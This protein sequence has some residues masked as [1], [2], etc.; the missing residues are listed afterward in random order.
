MTFATLAA[1]LEGDSVREGFVRDLAIVLC[2]A[3]V[4]T[5]LFSRL[6]QPVVLGYLLAGLIV[7]PYLTPK[8][9]TDQESIH[10]LSALGVILLMFSLGLEFR[11]QKIVELGSSAAFVAVVEVGLMLWLG[12]SAGRLL[13]WTSRECLF[14]GGIVAVSSTMLVQKSFTELGVEKRIREIVTGILV[15]EDIVAVV[16]IATL[17]AFSTGGELDARVVAEAGLRL[18][19]FLLVTVAVGLATVPRAIRAILALRR[20][21]T[22]LV[23]CI[24]LSFAMALLAERW[25][26]SQALGAFLAGV[27]VAESGEG[28]WIEDLVRPVRDVF[29]AIFFVSVGMLIDPALI[30]EHWVAV[31]VLSVLVLGGKVTG[32]SFATFLTGKDSATALRAGLCMAQIGELSFVIAALGVTTHAA[33]EF[34][35]PVAVGVSSLT[36]FLSPWLVRESL[37]IAAWLEAH[38]PRPIATFNRLYGSWLTAIRAQ[39]KR[40]ARWRVVRRAAI[41]VVL[42]G[43]LLGALIVAGS[44]GGERVAR[45][46]V[47]W[48]G[49]APR[50]AA[51]LVVGAF[52]GAC[53]F[54]WIGIARGARRLAVALSEM[55]MPSS[56]TGR[57]DSAAAPRRAL[58]VG[59]QLAVVVCVGIPLAVVTEPFLPHFS[60]PAVL[61]LLVA[62]ISFM[63][64]RSAAN[65]EGHVRAGAE[66]IVEALARGPKS[67]HARVMEEVNAILPGLGELTMLRIETGSAATSERL[68]DLASGPLAGVSVVAIVRGDVHVTL[69]GGNEVLHEGDL[70]ALTGAPDS[71]ARAVRELTPVRAAV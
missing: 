47:E 14:A 42:D 29:A 38:L 1:L 57:M 70:V 19:G 12:V 17:T 54:P 49:I 18:G 23:A 30:L 9:V 60:S 59:L 37:P 48:T 67:E 39:T 40:D 43:T 26:C 41:V 33:R 50:W 56:G 35:Y 69:P 66:V 10:A 4:T 15:F 45:A 61:V 2:V 7:G 44:I 6:R 34:L 24:G 31:V 25:G 20:K 8:L 11:F 71:V 62:P 65:L 55:A 3:A 21:E 28:E 52:A 16:L 51:A 32:V 36:A 5:V 27:L 13:G 58:V 64:W 46:I 22:V 68:R 63:L 53:V